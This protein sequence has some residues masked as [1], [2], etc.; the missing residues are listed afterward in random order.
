[1]RAITIS[2]MDLSFGL[3]GKVI[4]PSV[5]PIEKTLSRTG[6]TRENFIVVEINKFI[7]DLKTDV[8]GLGTFVLKIMKDLYLKDWVG[9][10]LVNN[11]KFSVRINLPQKV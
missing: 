2:G 6:L 3:I 11:H 5:P 1:M 4:Q 7:Q 9:L 10:G 8:V